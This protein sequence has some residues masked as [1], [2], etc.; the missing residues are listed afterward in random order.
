MKIRYHSTDQSWGN[1]ISAEG[2]NFNSAVQHNFKHPTDD[3]A[4]RWC[5]ACMTDTAGLD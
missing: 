3:E 4:K 2:H 1:Q 5:V